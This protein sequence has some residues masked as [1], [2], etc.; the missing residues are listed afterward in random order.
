MIYATPS[1]EGAL[2][3]WLHLVK[4]MPHISNLAGVLRMVEALVI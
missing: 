4:V 3:K 2:R 1:P